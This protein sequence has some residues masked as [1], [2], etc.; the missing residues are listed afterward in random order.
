MLSA[1]PDHLAEADVEGKTAY[2]VHLHAF[3]LSHPSLMAFVR[4]SV[5]ELSKGL[6]RPRR[7]PLGL[8]VFVLFLG[9]ILLSTLLLLVYWLP[10]LRRLARRL[11]RAL[12]RGIKR[13]LK[14]FANLLLVLENDIGSTFLLMENCLREPENPLLDADGLHLGDERYE[15]IV[16]TPLMMDFGYKNKTA[17]GEEPRRWFHYDFP[18][19]K[20]IVEQVVDVFRAIRVYAETES[21]PAL[22]AK[23]PALD[24]STRRV[25]EIYPFLALN[26][27]N[28][29]R[30]K[31]DGLLEKYFAHYTGRRADYLAQFAQFDGNIDHLGDHVFAGIKVYPPLG[32]DPWPEGDPEAMA[33]IDLFYAACS[34]KGIPLITHGGKGGF[35]TVDRDRLNEITDVSKWARALERYPGLWI[36]LA[37]FPMNRLERKRQEETLALVLRYDNVYVDVSCRATSDVYYQRLRA[38]LDRLPPG[39]AENLRS[40]ILFGTDFAVNLMWIESYNRYLD[41]FSRTAALTPEEKDAFCSVN[42][43]RFLFRA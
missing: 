8:L 5:R 7:L 31:I 30:E 41:L 10:P 2:D 4:R 26:P 27:A 38:L 22:A 43:E 9:L 1:G 36:D 34:E 39:D 11:I 19:G 21:D 12:V 23:Y 20:P 16:L 37:H 17:P 28:Y 33:K 18:A 25:F 42:P 13:L 6:L 3:N 29:T 40:R 32:F 24:P 35:V 14:S 15:R